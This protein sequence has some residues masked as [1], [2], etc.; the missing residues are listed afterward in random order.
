[1]FVFGG[2]DGTSR[3]NDLVEFRF[4]ID[5]MSCDIPE[6]TLIGNLRDMVNSELLSDVTF[7]VEGTP[8]HAHKV[9]CMRCTYFRAMLTGEM[10]ESRAKTITLPDV[11][12]PIFLALLEYL[13]TDELDV[14]LEVA[15]E[16]FQAADQFGV[17]RLKRMCES[18]ML[19]SIEVENAASIFHAADERNAK[20]M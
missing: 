18:T 17:D 9:L 4:S 5:L 12:R 16:L 15:M 8:V 11:R 2:Y 1:M 3:L 6:S 20:V 19:A 13:Y 7:I 14:E 10:K